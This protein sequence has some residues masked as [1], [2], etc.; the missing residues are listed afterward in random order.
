MIEESRTRETSHPAEKPLKLLEKLITSTTEE[1][2]LVVDPFAGCA[3]TLVAAYRNKRQFWG[4][5]IEEVYWE[6][7]QQRLLKV[8]KRA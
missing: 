4:C 7:G 5:E 2:E 3:S 6:E 1:G 8:L